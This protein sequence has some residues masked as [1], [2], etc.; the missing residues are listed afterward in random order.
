MK[1]LFTAFNTT[2]RLLK[3]PN[4]FTFFTLPAEKP[5]NMSSENNSSP[6]KIGTHNGTFHC[7][8]VLACFMLR[9]LPEFRESTIVRTRDPKLLAECD[10]VVDVGG[11]F[12]AE[13]KLFDHHQRSFNESMNSLNSDY[14]WTTK[15]SSAGLI[16]YHYGRE[17]VK[18]LLGVHAE[19]EN[20]VS[21]VYEKMYEN[22]MEEVD[23]IDNGVNQFDGEK[24]Y[25]ISSTMSNRVGHLNPPWNAV[26]P[27]EWKGFQKALM[28]VGKEFTDKIEYYISV[29]LPA[30]KIVEDAFAK[31][32]EVDSSMQILELEQSCP[33][34]EH[35][36][37]IEKEKAVA[38]NEKIIY[39]LYAD[40]AGNCRIQCVPASSDTFENRKSIKKEW[41]GIRDKELSDLS[42][43]DGC[44]FVHAS[45]FIGGNKT[46]S[47]ALQMAK[48]SLAAN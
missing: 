18:S 15:L 28:L 4:R 20:T 23:A 7:D 27:D 40:N 26:N 3:A 32:G 33:W 8:E 21:M 13:K 14:K 46:K 11:E 44:I 37:E 17:V 16:Y 47:G 41:Q 12:N 35:L 2:K 45:G 30:R 1:I 9:L 48:E 39:V 24:R 34:K 42:G 6:V 10:I 43:I 31:R 25:K 5:R 36:F 22:F 29:W 19:N 38:D